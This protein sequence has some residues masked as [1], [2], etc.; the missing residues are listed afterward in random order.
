MLADI[1]KDLWDRERP[2]WLN[3]FRGP[4]AVNEFRTQ[5]AV[6]AFRTQTAVNLD[7]TR[8]VCGSSQIT[9]RD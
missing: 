9:I 2:A 8:R 6:K 3:A 4:T 7:E 5:T 1:R